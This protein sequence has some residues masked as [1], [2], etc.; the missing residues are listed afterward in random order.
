[1]REEQ[2]FERHIQ[3]LTKISR[4]ITSDRYIEDIL[5][6]V[7]TVTAETMRSKICS[8]WLL[9][10]NDNAL[11]LRATQSMSEDYLKERSLKIG[12]GIV[13]HVA[14]TWKPR[15]VLNVLEEPEYKEKE[16]ALKEGLVSML[17]VPM[18]VKDRV[19]GVI[20]CYTSCPHE[21]TETEKNVLIT[22]ANEA[23]VAIENTELL[24][25]TR[26][27]Q[28]ELESRKLVERAKD[29]LMTQRGLSGADAYR[30]IQKRSMD[31][32]KS[33][34]EISEAI[35]LTEEI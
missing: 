15:S 17:S 10:D 34:R 22:V 7:V 21:F 8:L 30:W 35:V 19:V 20:N 33:M 16:L 31:T 18:V 9:D 4:A 23:A 26:V 11:K 13:G 2:T 27:I 28:E 12:E 25:K 24:V 3:A 32:R 5:R 1:M 6:L 29:V 14:L